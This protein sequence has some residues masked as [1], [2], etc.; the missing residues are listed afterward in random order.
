MRGLLL[1]IG[2]LAGV[3]LTLGACA[4]SP[5]QSVQQRAAD[6]AVSPQGE[7]AAPQGCVAGGVCLLPPISGG[8][9]EPWMELDGDC[10]EG[11]GE[12][13]SSAG[14]TDAT[15]ATVESCPGGGGDSGGGLGDGGGGDGG[16]GDGDGDPGTC[17]ESVTSPC[18]DGECEADCEEVD[19]DIC[20]QPLMGKTVT[21]LIEIAG[22]NH[23]FQF[24]GRMTRVNPLVGR[25]PAWYNISGPTPSKDN[26]WI[27]ESGTIQ[28]VCW[29]GWRFR[30]TV[31][32]GTVYPQANDLHMVMGPGHPDF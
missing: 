3:V 25:S 28:L 17:I 10:E 21:T 32:V 13:L 4:D 16:G 15:D 24:S 14:P 29:G 23:E 1:Q 19:S 9:C 7:P 18:P 2:V 11:G 26:W 22:R 6:L 31:W 27:A 5:T 30:N 8:W 12:C 20:P